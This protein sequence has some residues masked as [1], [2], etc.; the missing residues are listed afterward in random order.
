MLAVRWKVHERF[1]E[2]EPRH[3]STS[4]RLVGQQVY[5]LR[6]ITS[7]AA[8][9]TSFLVEPWTYNY[10]NSHYTNKANAGS[11]TDITGYKGMHTTEVLEQ[12]ALAMID[13]G[14]L[15]MCKR[16]LQDRSTPQFVL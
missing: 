1:Q 13:D 15:L 9:V 16:V 8:N 3:S 12:K 4:E 5:A 11:D 6:D 7:T 10:L 2:L 14:K